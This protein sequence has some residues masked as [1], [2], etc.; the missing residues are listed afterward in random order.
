MESGL[1]GLRQEHDAYIT[2]SQN[3]TTKF[4]INIFGSSYYLSFY[5]PFK[6]IVRL[7]AFVTVKNNLS[8]PIS[9]L[10][11]QTKTEL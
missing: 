7:N 8:K 10:I 5:D 1:T 9:N 11:A 2:F 4:K 6:V 3:K